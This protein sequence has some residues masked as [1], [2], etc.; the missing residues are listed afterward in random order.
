[1]TPFVSRSIA[2]IEAMP[3]PPSASETGPANVSHDYS[4]IVRWPESVWRRYYADRTIHRRLL[5]SIDSSLDPLPLVYIR[6]DHDGMASENS[7]NAA[8]VAPAGF[9]RKI[10]SH[11]LDLQKDDGSHQPV[12]KGAVETAV[13]VLRELERNDFAPPMITAQGTEA[14]VMLWSLGGTTYAITITDGELGY[15]VRRNKKRLKLVDSIKVETFKL[16]DIK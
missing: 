12:E 9:Y 4:G 10:E 15:V 13:L 11:L 14:V 7:T 16:L 1:M 3:M 6:S 5:H 2:D 8:P